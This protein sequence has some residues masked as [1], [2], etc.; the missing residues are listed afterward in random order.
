MHK[1]FL[2]ICL[3]IGNYIY[4]QERKVIE[5]DHAVF[6]R[7]SE[8]PGEVAKIEMLIQKINTIAINDTQKIVLVAGWMYDHISFDEVK[9]QQG[10]NITDYRTVFKTRKGICSDYTL[11][12]AEFCN[13]L[14]IKNEIIEGY[15]QEFEEHKTVF[16][17][18]NHAWNVVKLGKEWFHCDLLWMSGG[19]KKSS[20]RFIFEKR[21]SEGMLLTQSKEFLNNHIPAD[22]MWQLSHTP[23]TFQEM[24][25]VAA[26]VADIT[27]IFDY[28]NAIEKYTALNRLQKS[29]RF[30]D[31]AY[32]YNKDNSRIIVV[33]YFNAAI[34]LLNSSKG[35]KKMVET[36]RKYLLKAQKHLP[37]AALPDNRLQKQ[38]ETILKSI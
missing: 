25:H 10:G 20:G 16:K 33:N 7:K 21:L 17:E 38:I 22:P 13:R 37:A 24:T 2:L 34:D 9:F 15:V 31:N 14:G 30:A 27:E 36:S 4:A 32:Q 29:L 6:E 23:L 12:F 3:L 35:D 28:K 11:L 8:L 1:L 5:L 19:I 18:T 26:P